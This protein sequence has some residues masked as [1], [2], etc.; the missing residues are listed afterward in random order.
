MIVF[1]MVWIGVMGLI[2]YG[3]WNRLMP[4]IFGL[5][6]ISFW[7]A[8]GLLVLSRVLFGRFGGWGRRMRRSRFIRGWRD[9]TPEERQRFHQAMESRHGGHCDDGEAAEKV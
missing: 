5:P 1:G 7:Q 2:I 6:V 4:S 8:L 9:L 3:L